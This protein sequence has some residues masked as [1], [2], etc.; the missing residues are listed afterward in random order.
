MSNFRTVASILA[1][2]LSLLTG[3]LIFPETA[4]GQYQYS[5]YVAALIS[6]YNSG[7][8]MI[9][10]EQRRSDR[11]FTPNF[12][13]MSIGT[14]M[15]I[16]SIGQISKFL[17]WVNQAVRKN[18]NRSNCEEGRSYYDQLISETDIIAV[19]SFYTDFNRFCRR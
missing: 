16:R 5:A 4:S 19:R 3:F 10:D 18:P 9:E 1:C 7:E 17:S 12:T 8:R 15:K 2:S 6:Q 13:S 14:Q 11:G